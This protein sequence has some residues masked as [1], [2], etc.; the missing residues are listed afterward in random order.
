MITIYII[1]ILCS[2]NFISVTVSSPSRTKRAWLQRVGTRMLKY[3][4]AQLCDGEP[5]IPDASASMSGNLAELQA[6][7]DR[8][9]AAVLLE[10]CDN[11]SCI[12][13]TVE[14]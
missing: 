2:E 14:F 9:P 1:K 7:F 11:L 13:K 3:P 6:Q 8:H 12:H 4:E 5:D 10:I